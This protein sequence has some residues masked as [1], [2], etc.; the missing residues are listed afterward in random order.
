MPKPKDQ[1]STVFLMLSPHYAALE[2]FEFTNPSVGSPKENIGLPLYYF[3]ED[4]KE[5]KAI[6]NGFAI[7]HEHIPSLIHWLARAL[8]QEAK[9]EKI[10]Q[11]E[12]NTVI[13]EQTHE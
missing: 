12:K 3:D 5:W 4:E 10:P 2:G 11:K 8:M 7:K 9:N 1:E 13:E 6:T